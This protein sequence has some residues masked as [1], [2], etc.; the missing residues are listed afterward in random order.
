MSTVFLV[1]NTGKTPLNI[2]KIKSS[3]GCVVPE[4]EKTDVAPGKSVE[5]K[6]TFNSAGRKGTQIKTVTIL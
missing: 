2:R 4:I 6:V 3:C 1:N 5:L